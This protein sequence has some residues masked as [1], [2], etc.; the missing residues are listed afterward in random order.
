MFNSVLE[1]EVFGTLQPWQR[2]PHGLTTWFEV[3]NF[4]ARTFFWCGRALRQIRAD[5]LMASAMCEDDRPGFLTLQALDGMARASTLEKLP[6]IASEFRN[7][8][9]AI[10][11]E[12][13]G[14]LEAELKGQP[15]KDDTFAW[16]I[17]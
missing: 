3:L 16:L 12:T 15:R 7:I 1:R 11:A 14:E 10:T 13:I 8:G 2:R 5:C 6:I 17:D 9:L 4:S